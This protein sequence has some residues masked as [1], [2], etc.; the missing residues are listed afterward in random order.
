[1]ELAN[2]TPIKDDFQFA[3]IQEGLSVRGMYVLQYEVQP[4][5]PGLPALTSCTTI[6]VAA[7]QPT[8]L[9]LQVLLP[10]NHAHAT[11]LA[12]PSVRPTDNCFSSHATL[13]CFAFCLPPYHRTKG[14]YMSR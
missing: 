6:A 4:S 13:H 5:L 8:S 14:G 2:R 9:E 1:M 11:V 12:S 10:A 3:S 7:G